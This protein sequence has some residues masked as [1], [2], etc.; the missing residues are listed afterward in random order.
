MFGRV[1]YQ[2]KARTRSKNPDSRFSLIW[3]WPSS[4]PSQDSESPTG[5]LH[6]PQMKTTGPSSLS[7]SSSAWPNSFSSTVVESMLDPSNV[8]LT[9]LCRCF[10]AFSLAAIFYEASPKTS[11]FKL[12]R[13][14]D[15]EIFTSVYFRLRLSTQICLVFPF[16]A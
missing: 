10:D 11:R 3:F 8:V 13:V 12:R 6:F 14:F 15:S 2:E 4:L 9:L 1:C 5:N 16:L 7:S